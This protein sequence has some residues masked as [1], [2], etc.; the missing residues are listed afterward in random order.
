MLYPKYSPLF[1]FNCCKQ[2]LL[3]SKV[4][5]NLNLTHFRSIPALKITYRKIVY[6]VYIKNEGRLNRPSH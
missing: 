3:L 6:V 4:K 1:Q 2:L 5:H